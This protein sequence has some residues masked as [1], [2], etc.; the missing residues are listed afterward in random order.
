LLY[1]NHIEGMVNENIA[2]LNIRQEEH[3][4]LLRELIKETQENHKSILILSQIFK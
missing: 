1:K 2:N 4:L 3:E